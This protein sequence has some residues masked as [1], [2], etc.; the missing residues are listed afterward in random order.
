MLSP[1]E[2]Y[3]GGELHRACWQLRRDARERSS[4]AHAGS[5]AIAI[6]SAVADEVGVVE[7]IEGF[8]AEIEDGSIAIERE[9]TGD[10]WIDRV[11]PIA[12]ASIAADDGSIDDGTVGGPSRCRRCWWCR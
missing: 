5:I 7:N 9:G 6:G 3:L 2:T 1:S 8:G 12:A 4:E 10:K 11:L